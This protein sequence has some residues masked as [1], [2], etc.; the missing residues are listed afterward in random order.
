MEKDI[1]YCGMVCRGC[2]VYWVSME[3]D[4]ERR[5]RM[6][7]EIARISNEMYKTKLAAEDVTGCG[8]CKG[9]SDQMFCK[10]CAIRPCAAEKGIENCAHCNDYPCDK[11]EPAFKADGNAKTLLDF[12][13]NTL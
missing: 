13:K 12:I 11:L 3:Q 2:P 6:Q 4:G 5:K 9:D 7:A 8:G 10:D 1:G